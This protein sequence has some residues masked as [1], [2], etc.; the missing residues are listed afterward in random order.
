VWVT[1]VALQTLLNDKYKLES[2]QGDGSR[3]RQAIPQNARWKARA[4]NC[5]IY[6]SSTLQAV[7]IWGAA[8]KLSAKFAWCF[9][10]KQHSCI[11]PSRNCRWQ[12]VH[13]FRNA[14]FLHFP[15]HVRWKKLIA[16][17]W[18]QCCR[19]LAAT[20]TTSFTLLN[21]YISQSVDKVQ[22]V[23]FLAIS[24]TLSRYSNVVCYCSTSSCWKD[25]W[26][27]L[28][29]RWVIYHLTFK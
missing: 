22:C 7:L 3:T 18:H 2:L 13:L 25:V 15:L 1:D 24:E 27:R 14:T 20:W 29:P 10:T 16:P 4:C 9:P 23:A 26:D 17:H 12:F 11:A 21:W 28:P 5:C 19:S 8:V 6:K